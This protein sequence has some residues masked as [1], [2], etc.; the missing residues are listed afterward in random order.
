ML[1][2]NYSALIT[3]GQSSKTILIS[4]DLLVKGD[5]IKNGWNRNV[6]LLKVLKKCI[7]FFT[8]GGGTVVDM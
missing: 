8:K 6:G 5:Y 1:S 7:N 2:F 3:K 4:W